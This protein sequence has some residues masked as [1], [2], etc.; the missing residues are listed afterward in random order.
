MPDMLVIVAGFP[1]VNGVI[2]IQV[3]SVVVGGLRAGTFVDADFGLNA[4]QA[5]AVVVDAAKAAQLA[6]N[7]VTVGGGDRIML[8]GGFV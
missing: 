4:S 8:A 7:N 3:E 6:Q 5:N 2:K 1:D